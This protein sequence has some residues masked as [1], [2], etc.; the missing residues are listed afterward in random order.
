M[1]L[2]LNVACNSNILFNKKMPKLATIERIRIIKLFNDLPYRCNRK[3][4]QV[5]KKAKYSYGI[6][7]SESGIP[8]LVKKWHRTKTIEDF[9]RNNR[10]KC[11]ISN[12]GILAINKALLE[13]Q[14]LTAK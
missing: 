3:Y 13:N 2:A 6:Q 7:I 1:N 5:S 14:F 4:H 10:S 11:L 12:S 8:R 9:P